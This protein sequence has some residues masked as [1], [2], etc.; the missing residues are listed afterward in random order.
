MPFSCPNK[1]KNIYPVSIYLM[2]DNVHI[3]LSVLEL[4]SISKNFGW[5]FALDYTKE[6]R[7][8][9]KKMSACRGDNKV[10]DAPTYSCE[11]KSP[12]TG[13]VMSRIEM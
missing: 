6:S 9:Y 4:P 1:V 10:L 11:G 12:E 2:Y 3:L 5:S 8:R 7:D 13:D